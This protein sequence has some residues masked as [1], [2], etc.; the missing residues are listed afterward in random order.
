MAYAGYKF[1]KGEDRLQAATLAVAVHTNQEIA[2]IKYQGRIALEQNQLLLESQDVANDTLQDIKRA[3]GIT[4]LAIREGFEQAHQQ[5]L[6][7]NFE[8]NSLNSVSQSMLSQL[9]LQ[10]MEVQKQSDILTSINRTLN[11]KNE[12]EA[13]EILEQGEKLIASQ[14]HAKSDR[15]AAL[16]QEALSQFDRSTA[17][18]PFNERAWML[19]AYWNWFINPNDQ[20]WLDYFAEAWRVLQTELHSS[21]DVQREIAKKTAPFLAELTSQCMC[22]SGLWREF[23]EDYADSCLEHGAEDFGFSVKAAVIKATMMHEGYNEKIEA[24]VNEFMNL[25]SIRALLEVI[26]ADIRVYTSEAGSR[27][28]RIIKNA[29]RSQEQ[30]MHGLMNMESLRGNA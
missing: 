24:D 1:G 4:Y 30:S 29:L 21:D 10:L 11:K 28:I 3:Q 12:V 25:F 18:D 22:Q 26:V 6:L 15:R 2:E 23:L 16:I 19:K 7:T 17:L 8:L 13:A 5:A 9:R 14:A 20:R 27:V